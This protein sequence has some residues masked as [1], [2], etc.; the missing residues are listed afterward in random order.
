MLY[1]YKHSFS[2]FSAKINSSQAVTLASKLISFLS[3]FLRFSFFF[4]LSFLYPQVRLYSQCLRNYMR[5]WCKK[6]QIIAE[7]EGVI[8]VFR[9]KTMQLHT[10]RSWDFLGLPMISSTSTASDAASPLQ[11]AYGQDVIVG[12]FDTG[13]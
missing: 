8:S 6:N 3:F 2:G 5:Y 12:V 7:M 9:S 11:L 10:T 4:L 13:F 1:S